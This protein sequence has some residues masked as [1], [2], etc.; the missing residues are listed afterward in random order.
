MAVPDAGELQYRDRS[1]DSEVS[2][3][4][5]GPRPDTS[6]GVCEF[7]L[8]HLE[9]AMSPETIKDL[10]QKRIAAA[11]KAGHAR[12]PLLEFGAVVVHPSQAIIFKRDTPFALVHIGQTFS[13]THNFL[14]PHLAKELYEDTK[15]QRRCKCEVGNQDVRPAGTEDLSLRAEPEVDE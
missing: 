1:D 11:A 13:V 3:W 5:G 6:E 8:D 7:G 9:G 2:G 14:Q 4:A 15:G 12:P 10:N